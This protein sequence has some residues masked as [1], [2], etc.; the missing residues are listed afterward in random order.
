MTATQHRR[1]TGE[2]NPS[3]NTNKDNLET[4]NY[5]RAALFMGGIL[6]V[7]A[8]SIGAVSV[9]D[10]LQEKDAL[11]AELE[12]EKQA[13]E[14]LGSA[15]VQFTEVK[16]LDDNLVVEI[17]GTNEACPNINFSFEGT[18]DDWRLTLSQVDA[19]GEEFDKASASNKEAIRGL[20]ED[21][22]S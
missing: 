15:G 1:A 8:L 4:P 9:I 13:A 2:V 7:L 6:S 22:C 16:S 11:I 21:L 5:R 14:A 17:P 10:D 20:V 3:P 19:A 12:A 18:P